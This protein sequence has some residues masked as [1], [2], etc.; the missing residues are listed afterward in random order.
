MRRRDRPDRAVR[1]FADRAGGEAPT[2]ADPDPGYRRARR[3]RPTAPHGLPTPRSARP[4]ASLIGKL[5]QH[6]AV[7][8]HDFSGNGHLSLELRIVGRQ[9][10]SAG[11]LREIEGVP[12]SDVH[13]REHLP[14]DKNPDRMTDLAQ[15]ELDHAIITMV[16]TYSPQVAR[17]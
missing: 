7:A 15:L 1:N 4:S 13:G 16:I 9:T 11:R 12:F 6:V 14:G 8:L 5:T 10:I 17:T 2:P 3:A